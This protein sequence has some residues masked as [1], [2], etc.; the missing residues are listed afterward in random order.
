MAGC[1]S[2]VTAMTQA[3]GVREEGKKKKKSGGRFGCTAPLW[4]RTIP[5]SRHPNPSKKVQRSLALCPALAHPFIHAPPLHLRSAAAVCDEL[6][7][8]CALTWR[9]S[10]AAPVR[11]DLKESDERTEA[12]NRESRADHSSCTQLP[13]LSIAPVSFNSSPLYSH[14][15]PTTAHTAAHTASPPLLHRCRRSA[16][17]TFASSCSN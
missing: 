7:P 17:R 2:A 1:A 11:V 4:T 10:S 12:E 3:I 16:W 13:L 14:H 6:H 15:L 9:L 8:I 5:R